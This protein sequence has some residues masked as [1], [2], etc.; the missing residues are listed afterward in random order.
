V[1]ESLALFVVGDR[2]IERDWDAYRRELDVMG[3]GRYLEIS[4]SGYDRA[5]GKK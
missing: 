3:L 1:N 4:Q 2:D 5:I